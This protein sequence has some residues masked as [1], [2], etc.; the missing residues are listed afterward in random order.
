MFESSVWAGPANAN[1]FETL[2]TVPARG[3]PRA[4]GPTDRRRATGTRTGV[5]RRAV[6]ASV[7]RAS[8]RRAVI[9]MGPPANRRARP[10]INRRAASSVEPTG[11][12]PSPSS[13][14][15][16]RRAQPAGIEP[17]R[18]RGLW[19]V[20]ADGRAGVIGANGPAC[21]YAATP[22]NPR[23]PSRRVTATRVGRI[24]RAS[25]SGVPVPAP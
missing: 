7:R 16:S 10:R 24:E 3:G 18:A 21:E 25:T 13:G 4:H 9:E 22:T 23:Q 12:E 19:P 2:C 15:R 8:S 17:S 14:P 11:V 6:P 1:M 20:M 5:E